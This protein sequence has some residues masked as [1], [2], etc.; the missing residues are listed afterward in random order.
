MS[1]K[2]KV[3]RKPYTRADGTHVKGTTYYTTDRGKP[4]KGPKTLPPIPKE[5]SHSL[6]QYG[7]KVSDA[8]AKRHKSL[9]KAAKDKGYL[10]VLRRLNL[11]R[12]YQPKENATIKQKMSKD[13]KYLSN[14]YK[15]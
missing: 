8:E 6:S 2:I 12:N 13:V 9:D 4:G 1:S 11:I 10:P 7:Y 15:H 14:K 3:T 5:P